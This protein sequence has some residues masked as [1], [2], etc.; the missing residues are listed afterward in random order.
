MYCPLANPLRL[1]LLSPSTKVDWLQSRHL[2]MNFLLDWTSRKCFVCSLGKKSALCQL[3]C[4]ALC[5]VSPAFY[6]MCLLEEVGFEHFEGEGCMRVQD[7]DK[8]SCI[9]I[10]VVSHTRV[11]MDGLLFVKAWAEKLRVFCVKFK[12]T[13]VYKAT[14]IHGCWLLLK[15]QWKT[16][17]STHL[18]K[19][20]CDFHVFQW[21]RRSGFAA[22]FM[23]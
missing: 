5:W 21:G 4:M 3:L 11:R 8:C 19:H 14:G 15:S 10:C 12:P 20:F 16:C 17:E 1:D 13:S 9:G 6:G 18:L 22:F 23:S 2:F 7:C